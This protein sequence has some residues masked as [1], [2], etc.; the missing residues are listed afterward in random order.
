MSSNRSLRRLIGTLLAATLWCAPAFAAKATY[1]SKMEIGNLLFFN[2]DT[3]RAIRAFEEAAELNPKAL[4]PHTS[5]LNL[6]VQKGTPESMERAISECQEVLN[7]KPSKEIH[8]LLGNLLRNHAQSEADPDKQKRYYDAAVHEIE[9]AESMGVARGTAEYSL[10]TVHLQKGDLDQA[11]THVSEALKEDP[12]SADAHLI[13]AVLAF[14][15]LNAAD[16][17][18]GT[19][20][21]APKLTVADV[22]TELD[23][24]I[25][26]KG[27]N[28][29]AHNTKA[30][31]LL[32]N[33]DMTQAA[34]EYKKALQDDPRYLQALIGFGSCQAQM[35]TKE[36]D[37][38]KAKEY[39]KEARDAFGQAKQIKG[40][41]KN[42]LYALGV[43]LERLGLYQE[44][45]DEFT[46][47]L[48]LETD[49]LTRATITLHIQ[50][51]RQGAGLQLDVSGTHSRL[52]SQNVGSGLFTN[53]SLAIPF[54]NLI[55]MPDD[56]K[57]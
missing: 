16:K 14:K 56:K 7:R 41:D 39:I 53:G 26:L 57:K 34:Q 4:D 51:L 1:A 5:L 35:A 32:A 11:Y 55:Q 20:G 38:D 29:E 6:Y 45:I 30:E 54:K 17:D 13:H 31:I 50:Q 46:H 21:G 40:D 8:L 49:P 47:D 15:R 23:S 37:P 27:T 3:D 25:K 22:L 28:A 48:A 19:K 42:I 36:T 43:T 9:T 2:G 44:A 24:A 12:N 10:A 52:P 18:A 33:G